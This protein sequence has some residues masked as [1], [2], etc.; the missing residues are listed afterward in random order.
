MFFC[1]V[2]LVL[3]TLKTYEQKV[4]LL[5]TLSRKETWLLRLHIMPDSDIN[6][7]SNYWAKA[8]W[9]K[10]V[11]PILESLSKVPGGARIGLVHLLPPMPTENFLTYPFPS[12]NPADLQKDCHWTALNFFK[13]PP[14]SSFTKADAVRET[15]L[16]DYYPVL[17]DP[18]YGDVLMLARQDGTV[19]HSSV[20]IADNMVY[21]KNSASY[22]EPFILMKIP[23]MIERFEAF[24]PENEHLK[25]LI[26]RSKYL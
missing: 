10:D 15:I 25:M 11:K 18:R 19:L 8:S 13:D 4:A 12:T 17:S 24:I 22:M 14:D 6:S 1:D 7:L 3:D 20:F 9:G 23:D 5:K 16:K 2:S 21:T 26:F